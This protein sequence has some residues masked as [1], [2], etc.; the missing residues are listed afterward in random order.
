MIDSLQRG[1]AAKRNFRFLNNMSNEYKTFEKYI[2]SGLAS[3]DELLI[4]FDFGFEDEE[5]L[6]FYIDSV[7]S[8]SR[9]KDLM[10]L[11]ANGGNYSDTKFLSFL[12]LYNLIEDRESLSDQDVLTLYMLKLERIKNVYPYIKEVSKRK[13]ISFVETLYHVKKQWREHLYR[14]SQYNIYRSML[15]NVINKE[16]EVQK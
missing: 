13:N 9:L 2:A 7:G 4:F 6:K 12:G 11:V 8:S 3:R 14:G 10:L 1:Y 15:W 5:T 16:L